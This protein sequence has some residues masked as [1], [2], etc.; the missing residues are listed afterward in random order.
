MQTAD[1]PT[2]GDEVDVFETMSVERV[3]V[4]ARIYRLLAQKRLE[5]IGRLQEQV[6]RMRSRV[7]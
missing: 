3:R 4:L 6:E 5:E 1:M 7:R 2:P